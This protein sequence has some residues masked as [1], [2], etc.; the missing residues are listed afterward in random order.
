MATV[1]VE[2]LSSEQR[3]VSIGEFADQWRQT[4]GEVVDAISLT[5][6]DV[7]SGPAGADLEVHLQGTDLSQLDE[8][9][10][11]L[12]SFLEQFQGVLDLED[13]LHF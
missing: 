9:A 12:R 2:L 10:A 3:R 6:K 7:S 11:Q 13:D 8:A 1:T 4:V 5:Y